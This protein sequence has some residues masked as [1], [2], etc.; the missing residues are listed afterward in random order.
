[1]V[2]QFEA[3]RHVVSVYGKS[4]FG[5]GMP[6]RPPG[7]QDISILGRPVRGRSACG[8]DIPGALETDGKQMSRDVQG[9]TMSLPNL[10]WIDSDRLP[11]ESEDEDCSA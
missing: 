1:M 3:F 5:H 2:S 9:E 8:L 11:K 4:P 7:N 6:A 10:A